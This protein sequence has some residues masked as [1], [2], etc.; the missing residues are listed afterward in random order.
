MGLAVEEVSSNA[1]CL[2]NP[3]LDHFA[4]DTN[5]YLV[6]RSGRHYVQHR[7]LSGQRSDPASV[8]KDIR[9]KS[10]RKYDTLRDYPGP[11]LEYLCLLL[12]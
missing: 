3:S 7:C 8:S 1:L 5:S 9:S 2:R 6:G 4:S 11:G 12:G 10:Q